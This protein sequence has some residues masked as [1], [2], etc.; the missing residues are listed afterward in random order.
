MVTSAHEGMH[1]IFQE[2]PEILGSVFEVL[3]VPLSAKATVDAITTDVT[4]A[5]PLERRVDTVLRIGPS[6][7]EDF[8]LAIESQSG[9][10]ASKE[11][12][13]AYYVAYLQA[14]FRLPVLLLVVCQDGP[15]AKWAA[16][17]FDCGT[18]GW[19]ALRVYPLVAGPDNLP[20]IT[21]ARTA[22]KN[23][24][25]AVLSA[26]AHARNPGC[27]AILEAISSA[28][29]ELR[30]TDPGTA[31][32]FFDFLEVTLGKTPAGEKWNRIM[33]FVSYFPGRGT[34]REMA[35][36]EGKTEGR[37]EG[38]A[39]GILSVLEVRGIPV[40]D[41]VRERITSCTDLDR[42]DTWLERSR[43]VE[44]AEELFDDES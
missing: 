20:V 13:W 18:R 27:D 3:G 14:K 22:A 30:E 40:T 1:R 39:K 15:T 44:R 10:V 5:R 41:S 9:K 43:T 7:G 26:L 4:E 23:L 11:A 2:R 33:S 21:D 24:A 12:S 34:V 16:G 32:Y 19:T 36:L 42:M 35:Y 38:E 29:Q 31:E 28:L 25:L 8:L 6:D 37:A 17:P